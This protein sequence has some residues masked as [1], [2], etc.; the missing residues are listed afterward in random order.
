MSPLSGIHKFVFTSVPTN[1]QK[2]KFAYTFLPTN[3]QQEPCRPRPSVAEHTPQNATCIAEHTTERIAQHTVA[4]HIAK[5][6]AEH[7]QQSR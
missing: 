7:T 6:T 5:H 3:K 1:N 2:D 4:E